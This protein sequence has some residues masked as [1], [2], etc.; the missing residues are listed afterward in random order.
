MY[1]GGDWEVGGGGLGS[2]A[3]FLGREYPKLCDACL[4]DRREAVAP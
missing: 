3:F 2:S 4:G 1:A